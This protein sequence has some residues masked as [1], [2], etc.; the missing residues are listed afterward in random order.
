MADER[1]IPA[2][3]L[4]D[5]ARAWNEMAERL[6]TLPLAP[7]LVYIVDNVDASVLPYL[8]EQFHVLGYEG[9]L[10]ATTDGARRQLIKN[11][12]DLHRY[13]GTEYAMAS[14]IEA[15]GYSCVIEKWW[16]Y[17]G[18]P[19]HFRVTIDVDDNGISLDQQ[20]LLSALINTY[21]AQRDVQDAV[22][23]AT[24]VIANVPNYSFGCVSSEIVTVLPAAAQTEQHLLLCNEDT[25][26]LITNE[27]GADVTS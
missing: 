4:D 14:A 7:L 11:S 19:Y 2:A 24:R 12:I 23:V 26:A 21:K 27:T 20:A 3:V 22:Q 5:S 1:L 8:A 16:E 17:G 25:G 6:G 13:K 15:L 10:L 18:D 9:W